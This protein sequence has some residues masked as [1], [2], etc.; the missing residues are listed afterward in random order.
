MGYSRRV[1]GFVCCALAVGGLVGANWPQWRG[2]D[3]QG[4]SSEIGL[5]TRWSADSPNLLWKTHIPGDGI[6]SPIV[7]N[8]RVY[9]TT[10]YQ[11]TMRRSAERITAWAAPILTAL[12]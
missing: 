12:F 9:L 1:L 5:P 7:Y 2:P 4:V 10:A 3:G 8:G 6:S 11:G